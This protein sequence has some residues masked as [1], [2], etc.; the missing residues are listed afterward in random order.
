MNSRDTQ[1]FVTWSSRW[2]DDAPKADPPLSPTFSTLAKTGKLRLVRSGSDL[3][4]GMAEFADGEF[5]FKSKHPFG[6]EDIRE[7]L[8]QEQEH[9][10]DLATAL[11]ED[12]PDVS[13]VN[14]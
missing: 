3:Y 11:G 1:N 2:P 14:A 8:R 13:E 10:I 4:F 9:Q 6:P 5:K 12:V 7:I